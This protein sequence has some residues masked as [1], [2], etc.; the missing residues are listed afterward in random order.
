[1][2][3]EGSL[4]PEV[5]SVRSDERAALLR[6]LDAGLRDGRAGQLASEYPTALTAGG[7][8]GHRIAR[9]GGSFAAHA[10]ARPI[11]VRAAGC[12]LPIGL[13]GLV[14]TEPRWRGRGLASACVEAC[15]EALRRE[16]AVLALLWSDLPDWYARLGFAEAGAEQIGVVTPALCREAARALAGPAECELGPARDAD[17]EALETLQ[18]ARDARARRRRGELRL[19]AAAPSCTLRVARRQGRP[20]AYAAAGRGDD[21]RGVIHEWA[22]EPD[23]VLACFAAL[24]ERTGELLWLAP[25]AEDEPARALRAA[26]APL[27]RR[28]LG[29]MRLLDA[30]RLL[31]S[32]AR[33]EPALARVELCRA[34]DDYALRGSQGRV[35]LTHAEALALLLGPERPARAI[36]ALDAAEYR[37][38]ARAL[39][40]PLYV[41]GFDSI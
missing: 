28:P 4:G 6:W 34:G 33:A 18:A 30:S 5:V 17:W 36:R 12:E 24:A 13:V 19:L 11:R 1:M 10:F 9:V 39:P 31:R 8:E 14:Y 21:F 26:G 2:R 25:N 32:V 20:A 35:A 22:G 15:V 7:V 37:A 41:S 29:W 27:D 23:G 40:W 16:G 38:L 3:S